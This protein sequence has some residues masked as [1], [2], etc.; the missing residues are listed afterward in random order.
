MSSLTV[1]RTYIREEQR[2]FAATDEK[3]KNFHPRLSRVKSV[4]LFST[5]CSQVTVY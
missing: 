3:K 4:H 2:S 1:G 5:A